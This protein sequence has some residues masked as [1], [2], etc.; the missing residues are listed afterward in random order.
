MTHDADIIGT[1]GKTYF[2]LWKEH[3]DKPRQCIEKQRLHF[4]DKGLYSQIYSFSSS[5]V[6]I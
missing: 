5:H 1:I 3:Y 2:A 4:A 6:Q